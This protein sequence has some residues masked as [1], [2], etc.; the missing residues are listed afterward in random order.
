MIAFKVYFKHHFRL[1]MCRCWVIVVAISEEAAVAQAQK[2]FIHKMPGYAHLLDVKRLCSIK[3]G[4]A[5]CLEHEFIPLN[6]PW[7]NKE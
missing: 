7:Y 5:Q 1:Q 3:T 4:G 6:N 2:E